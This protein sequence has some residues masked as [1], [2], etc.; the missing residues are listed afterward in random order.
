MPASRDEPQRDDGTVPAPAARPV[1]L[2]VDL[3]P[4]LQALLQAW[5]AEIGLRTAPA[6]AA[7][8]GAPALLLIGL[9]YPRQGGSPHLHALTAAW[10][11]IPAI[12]LSPTLLAGVA[13][14]GEVARQ[15]GVQ[16]V[17]PTPV[18]REALLAAVRALLEPAR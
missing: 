3:E 17:L 9:P 6:D 16:A 13:A 4:A 14:R 10:P 11:G 7:P 8:P 1:A 15:L 5:L 12:A 2:L 18:A